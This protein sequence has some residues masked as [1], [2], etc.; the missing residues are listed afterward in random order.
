MINKAISAE[1]RVMKEN[2]YDTLSKSI[3]KLLIQKQG[4]ARI[5]II[6]IGAAKRAPRVTLVLYK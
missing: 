1:L 4:A 6:G 3:K 2:K 5:L